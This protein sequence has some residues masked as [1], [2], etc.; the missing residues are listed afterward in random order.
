[1][2]PRV[3]YEELLSETHDTVTEL[4]NDSSGESKT[5]NESIARSKRK[6]VPIES[7][8]DTNAKRESLRGDDDEMTVQ[9]DNVTQNEE[10]STINTVRRIMRKGK[11]SQRGGKL[12]METTPSDFLRVQAK[13]K[14]LSFK[15]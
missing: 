2:I 13:R 9:K 12:D 5:N 11:K 8:N 3:K 7:A 1:M 6:D 15:L 10:T 4:D 14:W